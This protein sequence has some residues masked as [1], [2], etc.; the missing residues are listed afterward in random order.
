MYRELTLVPC[1]EAAAERS[2][3]SSSSPRQHMLVIHTASVNNHHAGN[4][5]AIWRCELPGSVTA[6]HLPV[7]LVSA[8]L[9]LQESAPVLR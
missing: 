8:S 3:N 9:S 6:A 2:D 5:A 1:L 4:S 7:L